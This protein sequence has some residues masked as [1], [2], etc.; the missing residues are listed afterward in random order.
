M[1]F[2]TF[3]QDQLDS[4]C[5][6]SDQGRVGRVG[7]GHGENRLD[8]R[9]ANPNPMYED[10]QDGKKGSNRDNYDDAEDVGDL[11]EGFYLGIHVSLPAL[12]GHA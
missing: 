6:R 9:H 7:L 10:H 2:K 8:G 5:C 4:T 3:C 12:Y 11:P 1:V